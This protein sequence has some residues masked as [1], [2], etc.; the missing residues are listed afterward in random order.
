MTG[1]R[2]TTVQAAG[3]VAVS[4]SASQVV[5]FGIGIV[6]A[7]L[8]VPDDFGLV[9]MVVGKHDLFHVSDAVVWQHAGDRSIAAVDQ[10]SVLAVTH[11]AHVDRTMI[12]QQVVRK[13]GCVAAEWRFR[14]SCRPAA[15]GP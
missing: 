5:S 4:K 14:C 12:D 15:G 8:L 7:R 6:L 1:L 10:Q 11:Y 3:W 13:L 9:A 2:A